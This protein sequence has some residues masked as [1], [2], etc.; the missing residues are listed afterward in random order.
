[1]KKTSA[2][3]IVVGGLNTDI[4]AAGVNE[5]LGPGELSRSGE[6]F[7]GPG[8]KSSNIARMTACLLGSERVFMLAKTSKDPYGLWAV[9]MKALAEAGVNTDLIR[10]DTMERCGKFPGI[11]LIPVNKQGENQIYCI[12]GINEDFSPS[13]IDHA[14][15]LF[16]ESAEE[17]VLAL[18]LEMP[19]DTAAH[20][21]RKAREY[22]LR[23]VLDP[24][25]IGPSQDVRQ[26]LQ[27][28]I[29]CIKP[30]EHEAKILTGIEVA[31]L[32]SAE[33][34]AHRLLD[35]GIV[36]VLITHGSEGAYLVSADR[37]QHIPV[38]VLPSATHA[39]ATGCGD[40]ATALLC[41]ET[42]RGRGI[43][44]AARTAVYAGTLQFQRLGI[45]PVDPEELQ[46]IP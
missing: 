37:A 23:V 45:E 19:L 11:A 25:G 34:A 13:D 10:V 39:D 16:K 5:L 32:S 7:I 26:L 17:G 41:S 46:D 30:N 6:L 14:E 35:Y 40:Q 3:I 43:D 31:D 28:G 22:G 4:V 44:E 24:G 42:L 33:R 8:G 21:I 2:R 20:T 36:H 15:A 12:P 9:P 1:M 18:T 27:G 38:P 29:Y